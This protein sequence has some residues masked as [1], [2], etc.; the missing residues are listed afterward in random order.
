MNGGSGGSAREDGKAGSRGLRVLSGTAVALGM[1]LLIGGFVLGAIDYRP[2]SVPTDSMDPTVAAGDRLMAQRIDGGDVRR[3]DVVI[4]NDAVWG[5]V[6]M[7]KRVVGIGGDKVACC[8]K[9]GRLKVNGKSVDEPYLKSK[10]SPASPTGFS[11]KVPAG[12]LFLL[13][14]NRNTS[15]DSRSH[16]TDD[17]GT[18]PRSAV[19]ARVDATVWP[20]GRMGFTEHVTAFADVGSVS[21]PGPLKWL[22]AACL[23]GAVLVFAG[24]AAG[25]VAA[26][27]ARRRA[28]RA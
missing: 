28:R 7:L 15:A 3:G 24:A 13:G 10:D 11:A 8:D 23:A 18:V 21:R 5:D 20:M 26:R 27:A 4:F 25:P 17:Q 19:T 9:R 14:D 16:L 6:P 22:L 12:H 1:A 2:F